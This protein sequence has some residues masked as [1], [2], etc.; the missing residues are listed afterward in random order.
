MNASKTIFQ[1]RSRELDYLQKDWLEKTTGI[2]AANWDVYVIKELID[3]ALDADEAAGIEQV[4]I[5]V[6]AIYTRDE[7]RNLFSL[8]IDIGNQAPFP[9]DQIENIFDLAYYASSKSGRNI[10]TRGKQ[11][12]ALKTIAGIPY[13]LRHFHYG[14]YE[15]NHRPLVIETAGC[16]HTV[17][18]QIDETT[19]K[20][21][22]ITH[23]DSAVSESE[24]NW[25]RVGIDRF[26]QETPR[27]LKELRELARSLALF[28][29]HVWFDWKVAMGDQQESL[30]FQ[31]GADWM[32]RFRG[33]PPVSWYDAAQFRVLLT[34]AGRSQT[35]EISTH[36]FVSSFPGFAIQQ[37][38]QISQNF[39]GTLTE[40]LDR[41]A[42][43][44]LYE[45]LISVDRSL[46]ERITVADLGGLGEASMSNHVTDFFGDPLQITY[47]KELTQD[48]SRPSCP[49]VLEIFGARFEDGAQRTLWTGINNTANYGDPF[50]RTKLTRAGSQA[51]AEAR[52]LREFVEMFGVSPA[53]PFLIAIHLIC[54]NISYQDF[55]K[56]LIE[57]SPFREKLEAILSDVLE[58]LSVGE[59]EAEKQRAVNARE[60]LKQFIPGAV[61]YLSPDGREFFSLEQLIVRI[62]QLYATKTATAGAM[63]KPPSNHETGEA[64]EEYRRD[65][66]GGLVNLINRRHVQVYLPTSNESAAFD[67]SSVTV[68][69]LGD[70]C[71]NKV[72]VFSDRGVAEVFVVN[73]F[74]RRFDAAVIAVDSGS[75]TFA[76]TLETIARWKLPLV[77]AHDASMPGYS[78]SER[79]QQYVK[80]RRLNS[81]VY[82]LGLTPAQAK[83]LN[84]PI[85]HAAFTDANRHMMNMSMS[86]EEQEFLLE[87]EQTYSLVALSPKAL[88]NW[89]CT[90]FARLGIPEK[91]VPASTVSRL[92][93]QKAFREA[94]ERWVLDQLGSE[95]GIDGVTDSVVKS[96]LVGWQVERAIELIKFDSE[97]AKKQSWRQLLQR[98]VTSDIEERL[99]QCEVELRELIRKKAGLGKHRM[100]R[101]ALR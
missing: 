7:R 26:F 51:G 62:R 67:V 72:L 58:E 89:V 23:A 55:S 75:N 44:S 36:D 56:T 43:Q 33:M 73:N 90:E 46:A 79:L 20:I 9:A 34:H 30:S 60:S 81:A 17:S 85:E 32:G 83:T 1:L 94:V 42:V 8:K 10:P 35:S 5:R 29:P 37:I 88:R 70:A 100:S 3:N 95:I 66:P 49:F 99:N 91:M 61:R 87:Q 64:I 54:P 80:E 53:T 28:N 45:K 101:P 52:G 31:G 92:A 59:E 18:Y 24:F 78:W 25:V 93:S 57:A 22:L 41:Q 63:V 4:K 77:L 19:D 11:G 84:L 47:R 69:M 68:A 97:D 13:A 38:D 6:N 86:K 71:V 76:D 74:P 65:H 14:D 98:L 16:R 39:P 48:T 21:N 12:N 82:D 2:Q 15:V 40:V 27:D 50:S 96:I